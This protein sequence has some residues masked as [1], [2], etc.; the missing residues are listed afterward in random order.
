M[1]KRRAT[2]TNEK[3]MASEQS[4]SPTK[5]L[6][7]AN[8]FGI[9]VYLAAASVGWVEP[10]L[11]NIPGAAGGGAVVWFFFSVPVLLL[12][13]L[14]NLLCVFL[15]VIHRYRTGYWYFLWWAWPAVLG[16]WISAV[17]FDFS[18]HGT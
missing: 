7:A 16:M 11:Q 13:F 5:I 2:V 9:V 10:E 8:S 12:S 3:S 4:V 15:T 17:A 6:L 14:S 1:E 18:R